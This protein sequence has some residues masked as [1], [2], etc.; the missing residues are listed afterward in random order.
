VPL[1][2]TC[3]ENKVTLGEMCNVLRRTWG[4]YQPAQWG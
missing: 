4:E 3:A 2:I 1:F